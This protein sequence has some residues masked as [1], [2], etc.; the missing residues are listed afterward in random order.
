MKDNKNKSF[1]MFSKNENVHNILCDMQ[2]NQKLYLRLGE[3]LK[4]LGRFDDKV[5]VD[6]YDRTESKKGTKIR[7]WCIDSEGNLFIFYGISCDRK[8]LLKIIKETNEEE[9]EYDISL[10]K[11]YS[12]NLENINFTRTKQIHNFKFGRLVTDEKTFYSLFLGSDIAYQI[13]GNFNG[14]VTKD[15]LNRLNELKSEPKFMDFLNVFNNVLTNNRIQYFISSI[16]AIKDFEL[17]GSF[18]LNIEDKKKVY[19]KEKNN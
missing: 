9:F 1:I 3:S 19:I 8:D 5:E 17:T 14:N 10:A 4:I 13:L 18:Q 2:L 16:T 11:K 12:L 7:L 6:F 15:L